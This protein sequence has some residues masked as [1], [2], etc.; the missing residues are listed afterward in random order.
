MR[1]GRGP[2]QLDERLALGPDGI[3]EVAETAVLNAN[4]L[5]ALLREVLQAARE[6][7]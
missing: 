1:T 6:T 4:Y 3:R 5:A 2:Q 7:W